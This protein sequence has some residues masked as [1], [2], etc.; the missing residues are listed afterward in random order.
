MGHILMGS[1]YL[2]VQEIRTGLTARFLN[3]VILLLFLKF[4]VH[5]IVTLGLKF[6]F[7]K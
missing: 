2:V 1:I 3:S 6:L 7:S 4:V 5:T